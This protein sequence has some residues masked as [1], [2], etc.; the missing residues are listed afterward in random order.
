MRHLVSRRLWSC[1]L[2]A[3]ATLLLSARAEAAAIVFDQVINTGIVEYDASPGGKLVGTDIR[4]GS[5]TGVDT[6]NDGTLVCTGC[7][8]NFETGA[9]LSENV[10]AGGTE[11]VF[12]GGGFLTLTGDFGTGN[13]TILSGSWNAPVRVDIIGTTAML[14]VG[15]GTDTKD[16]DLLD[17]FFNTPP[18]NFDFVNSQILVQSETGGL[19]VNGSAFRADLSKGGNADLINATVP[20]P[21]STLL[22]GAGLLGLARAGRRRI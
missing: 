21:I 14:M 7:L 1:S 22:L 11:Y 4:F 19:I 10:G 3:L 16:P 13:T 2:V 18:T 17:I 20:E 12:D 8:L 6:D 5:I 15:S 9:L